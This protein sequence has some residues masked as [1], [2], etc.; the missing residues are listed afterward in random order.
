MK[1]KKVFL[2]VDPS[3]LIP[4]GLDGILSNNFNYLLL[5]TNKHADVIKSIRNVK[6]NLIFLEIIENKQMNLS[7]I[8]EI[9]KIQPNIEIL[10]FTECNDKF[11]LN[12][13]KKTLNVH[14]LEKTASKNEIIR[15][16]SNILDVNKKIKTK[17]LDSFRLSERERQIAV[18]LLDGMKIVEISTHLKLSMT[19]VSTYKYRVFKKYEIKNILELEK[20]FQS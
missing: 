16:V 8:S 4:I 14:V 19:T 17:R 9:R 20:V 3:I 11:I 2:V 7:I 10:V 1:N 13:L 5:K 6:I 12:Q 15:K 18:M